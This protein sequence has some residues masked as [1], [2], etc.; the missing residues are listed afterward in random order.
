MLPRAAL[1]VRLMRRELATIG[2]VSELFVLA[3]SSVSEWDPDV[4]AA[5]HVGADGLV[6][7]GRASVCKT[8]A[9]PVRHVFGRQPL[10][11]GVLASEV[12]RCVPSD[13]RLI[14]LPHARYWSSAEA[15]REAVAPIHADLFIGVL[16]PEN[17]WNE[18][19]DSHQKSCCAGTGGPCE[20]GSC[21]GLEAA[22]CPMETGSLEERCHDSHAIVPQPAVYCRESAAEDWLKIGNFIVPGVRTSAEEVRGD[23]DGARATHVL[24]VGDEGA[25]L[26]RLMLENSSLRFHLYSPAMG[27][28]VAADAMMVLVR[29]FSLCA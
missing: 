13:V 18:D 15:V 10:S 17:S 25:E 11:V 24:Y 6:L 7:Y 29:C 21:G 5:H 19:L 27:V 4:I 20:G 8:S 12:A 22:D 9:L 14:I 2:A 23:E 26:S 16:A 3:D 1:L 28:I